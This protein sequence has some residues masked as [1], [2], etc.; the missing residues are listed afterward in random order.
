MPTSRLR[1]D[2]YAQRRGTVADG[3]AG[4]KLDALLVAFSPNVRYL[5]GFTGSNGSLLVMPGRA[6]LFSDPRYQIQA[7]EEVSCQ[8]KIAKG[9]LVEAVAGAISR[10]RLRRIGYEPARMTCD[11]LDAL[12]GKIPARASLE[13][14]SGWIEE[15]RMIKSAAELERIRKSVEIN[16]R[17]FEQAVQQVKPGMRERDLAAELEYRMRRLG[18]EKP[19]FETI[20]AA[21]KR[22]ALPHAQPTDARIENGSLVVVDMGAVQ[23]GYSSD[24]TRMLF[25]GSPSPKVRRTYRAVLEA[26]QS[27]IEAVRPGASTA[28]V[29]RKAR[30]VLEGYGL[31]KAFVHSTGHGLGLE[32][33]E[34]PR[35]GK[36]DKQRLQPGM[37][38]TIEPGVYLEGFGGIRIED[39]V[40]VTE[41]GCRILTPTSKELRLV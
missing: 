15:L 13:P 8:V 30:K 37:A 18:A 3:L 36:R 14:V 34:P 23:E 41:N 39:T 4:R 1:A 20:V 11:W 6:I 17:A 28:S 16:S 12:R 35:L 19:A 7:S 5:S 22:G 31:E 38:I 2:E 33:H 27:A 26:Q 24:M 21:G 32:I 9:S 40:V 29:D 25:L 10:L